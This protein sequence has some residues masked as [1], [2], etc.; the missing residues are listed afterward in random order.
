[1]SK[2]FE[3]EETVYFVQ[4]AI[5]VKEA[6][7][8]NDSGGFIMIKLPETGGRIQSKAKQILQIKR[9]SRAIYQKKMSSENTLL[10]FRP[11]II[12]R[13]NQCLIGRYF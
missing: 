10:L 5:Y 2:K 7:V 6:Q 13:I 8:I 9:R 4:S 1:M 3:K 12:T 11:S